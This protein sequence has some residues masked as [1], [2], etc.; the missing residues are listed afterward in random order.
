[1]RPSSNVPEWSKG[2]PTDSGTS[3]QAL[4]PGEQVGWGPC[5]QRWV[6]ASSSGYWMDWDGDFNNRIKVGNMNR[7]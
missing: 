7:L 6:D 2:G 4:N 5:N 3:A 1:M